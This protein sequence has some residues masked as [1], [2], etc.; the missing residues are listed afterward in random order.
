MMTDGVTLLERIPDHWKPL[1]ALILGGVILIALVLFHGAGLH[2]ILLRRKRLE[3]D[4][5]QGRPHVVPVL[6]LFA[7]SVFLMLALHVAE[8]SL[9]AVA[10]MKMGLI[11]RAYNAIYFCANAYT[12][13]G[14]GNVD[15]DP[16]WRNLSPII[17][18][19]GLFTMAWTTGTLATVIASH[20]QLITQMEEEREQEA[21]MRS[22]LRQKEWEVV[23]E[24]RA[25]EK[26][27]KDKTWTPAA[28]ASF[29]KR[30]ELWK[31]ERK[32]ARGIRK[33]RALEVASLYRTER[34]A[35]KQLGRKDD[36]DGKDS[37][38][39]SSPDS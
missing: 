14:Y 28:G 25:A 19:S 12:T 31:S 24:E 4:L 5:R 23:R 27:E 39:V 32:T 35:E 36:T 16:L 9:W 33:A 10:L 17:G 34:A 7:W 20:S 11:P 13:L 6:L 8:F 26:V 18:I 37:P 30:R 21:H 15:L 38:S 2:L 29:F 22:A 1:A 3:R